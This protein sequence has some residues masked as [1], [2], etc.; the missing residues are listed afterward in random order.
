ML[1]RCGT[2]LPSLLLSGVVSAQ[3]AVPAANAPK[4]SPMAQLDRLKGTWVGEARGRGPDGKPYAVTQTERVGTMLGGDVL[5]IEG[6]G[7]KSDGTLAFNALGTVSANAQTGEFEFRAHAMGRSGTYR[8]EATDTGVRW[9]IPAGPNAL[10]RYTIT[11]QDGRWHE[12]GEYLAK[13]QPPRQIAELI[14]QRTGDT[15]WPAA[16]PVV[17]PTLHWSARSDTKDGLLT[18]Q[19]LRQGASPRQKA[20]DGYDAIDTAIESR[21]RLFVQLALHHLFEQSVADQPERLKALRDSGVEAAAARS[22]AQSEA[23]VLALNYAI[24]KSDRKLFDSLLSRGVPLGLANRSGHFP[25]SL[26]ASWNEPE[27]V[28]ALLQGHAS[29]DQHND[30][31][32]KTTP[33]ME[34][35]RHTNV[36]VA[37]AL[38][39]AGAQVNQP[40]VNQ[41]HALNWAVYFGRTP[42]VELLLAH[43]ANVAQVG[44]DSQDNALDIAL[45]QNHPDIVTLLKKAGAVASRRHK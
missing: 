23:A 3:V 6:R 34:S 36:E 31:R 35:T 21:N 24:V 16:N 19:L 45:R 15:D 26:A 13:D 38:L 20:Q 2:W 22:D 37:R 4:S 11:L 25:L 29:V 44:Q 39:K 42:L 17:P 33:L 12:I 18:R 43:Q 8:L 32:Y 28:Q 27:M 5:V 10:V 7:Y 41:D 30:N 40:D 14:L 9:E 1:I